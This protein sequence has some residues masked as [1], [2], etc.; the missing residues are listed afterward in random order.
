MLLVY[1]I[2]IPKGTNF[3]MSSVSVRV[4]IKDS[5]SNVYIA[6]DTTATRF[7]IFTAFLELNGRL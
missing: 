6:I 5:V 7:L 3:I 1:S 4:N 2:K